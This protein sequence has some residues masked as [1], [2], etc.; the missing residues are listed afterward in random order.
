MKTE[1]SRA[2]TTGTERFT[3]HDGDKQFAQI[4]DNFKLQNVHA[5]FSVMYIPSI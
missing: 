1:I 3:E 2:L 4:T 5:T